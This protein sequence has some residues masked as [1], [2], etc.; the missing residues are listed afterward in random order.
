MQKIASIGAITMAS[1]SICLSDNFRV[2]SQRLLEALIGIKSSKH[3]GLHLRELT[4]L[5]RMTS[6]SFLSLRSGG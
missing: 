1:L 4:P 5:S 2:S 3:F 6:V